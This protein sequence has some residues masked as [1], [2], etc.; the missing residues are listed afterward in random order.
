MSKNMHLKDLYHY[1]REN[2]KRHSIENPAL[3]TSILLSKSSAIKDIADIYAYPEMELD[4]GKVDKFNRLMERRIKNEP[5]AYITGEKEFYS[6][7]F[8]VNRSVLIPRPETELLI[9]ETLEAAQGIERPAILDIGTGCGCVAVTLAC[10]LKDAIV[11]A[12]DVSPGALA[13]ASEN[14]GT[15]VPSRDDIHFIRASLTDPFKKDAFDIV[16]SNPPYI[17]EAEFIALPPE[18]RDYEPRSSLIAGEDGLYFIGKIISG[19]GDIL[20]NG[21]RCLLEIGAGQSAA[22]KALFERAGFAEISSAKDLSGIE[23]VIGARWRK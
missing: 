3:E 14:A 12:S 15:H 8:S 7:S 10:E 9:E 6:R 23:R 13:L 2:M 22:V 18:I 21:G 17:S 11:Y 19:A 5:I 1:G 16:V 4:Q 20:K